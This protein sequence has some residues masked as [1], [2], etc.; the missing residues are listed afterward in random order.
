MGS[1]ALLVSLATLAAVALVWLALERDAAT[2]ARRVSSTSATA[3]P[4]ALAGERV[5]S[6]PAGQTPPAVRETVSGAPS[7]VP[8]TPPRNPLFAVLSG[9]VVDSAAA[10]IAGA[11]VRVRRPEAGHFTMLD[12]DLRRAP[13]EVARAVSDAEGRFAFEFER[14]IPFDL[15]VSASGFCDALLAQR[16][17]GEEL[18]VALSSGY[19]VHGFVRRERDLAPIADARVLVFQLGGAAA[20]ERTTTTAGDGS[21]RMR[22]PFEEAATLEVTPRREQGSE[23]LALEFDAEGT[24]RVDLLLADGIEVRGR[25][26]EAGSGEPIRGAR[27]G[28]GW[29]FRRSAET[30]ARGEYVL[31]GFG[32]AGALELYA[33]A[34][35]HGKAQRA[36]LPA[37][38]DGVL[39]VDF[40]LAR[41]RLV[42]GRVLDADGRPLAD[43]YVAAVASEDGQEGQ[44]TDWIS[45]RSDFAGRFELGG[46]TPELRHCLLASAAGFDTRVYDFPATELD[47]LELELGDVRLAPAAMLAGIVQDDQGTALAGMEVILTGTNHDRARWRGES[48]LPPVAGWYVDSR[49][50]TTDAHG[51]FWFGSLPAGEFHL[52][53]RRRG[54]PSSRRADVWLAGGELL[55]GLVLVYPRGETI[56]GTVVDAEGRGLA[57]VYLSARLTAPR[58]GWETIQVRVGEDDRTTAAL[59]TGPDGAFE[60]RGLVP[61][62]Y[63][64]DLSPFALASDPDRPWLRASRAAESAA[65]DGGEESLRIVLPRGLSIRG[66]LLDRA[67]AA[68]VGFVVLGTSDA[69]P[70]S[71]T[72]TS[73]DDGS[74]VLE[75]LPG[76]LWDLEVRGAWQTDAWETIFHT[77]RGVTAGTREL[78]LR[79]ALGGESLTGTLPGK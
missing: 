68:L 9:R 31:P 40:E 25:V 74:F 1:K 41:G 51:R 33:K 28:E 67:G 63:R 18:E 55:E 46:L 23:W 17:A 11:E 65:P 32:A 72:A 77:E 13:R 60:L 38:V 54:Q 14:G 69:C 36:N 44:R 61:G 53:A 35:G 10:P 43:A 29:T 16:Y 45:G 59:Q 49:E 22:I 64:L 3:E 71:P 4:L 57:G 39:R 73:G 12:L 70:D 79:V 78:E 37:A 30:D 2:S 5:E 24:A 75:V 52:H 34:S 76:T 48:A 56:R 20:G 50:A 6:A 8:E 66:R 62:S 21:Y 58:A 27:V 19:L 42:R 47:E 15:A 7:E 26:V